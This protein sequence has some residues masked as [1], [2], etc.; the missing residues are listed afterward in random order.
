MEDK[1]SQVTKSAKKMNIP[2]SF[3]SRIMK[4][5]PSVSHLEI[6]SL[7]A[8]EKM[9]EQYIERYSEHVDYNIIMRLLIFRDEVL[10]RLT[11]L[12]RQ[13]KIKNYYKIYK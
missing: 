13:E 5:T 11:R 2:L 7:M 9:C 10:E 1:R 8:M 3:N 6:Q 4:Y 12:R